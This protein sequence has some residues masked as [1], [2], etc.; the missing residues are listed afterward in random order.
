MKPGPGHGADFHADKTLEQLVTSVVELDSRLRFLRANAAFCEL[1][2]V[3]SP[4]LRDV[5][6]GDFGK[7]GQALA[8]IAERA[9]SQQTAVASRG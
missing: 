4:K 3:G 9:R 5:A 7:A 8:P 6:L 2:E 1:F